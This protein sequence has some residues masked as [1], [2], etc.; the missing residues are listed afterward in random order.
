ML[1]SE[2][3]PPV[4]TPTSPPGVPLD[5]VGVTPTLE[6]DFSD[7]HFAA[8]LN[9]PPPE[10]RALYQTRLMNGGGCHHGR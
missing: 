2:A 10:E 4:L 6:F 1:H 9:V 5:I 8:R 7:G 3:A